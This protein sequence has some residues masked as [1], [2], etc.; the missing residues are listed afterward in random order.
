VNS[1]IPSGPEVTPGY[2]LHS[3][4]SYHGVIPEAVPVV[5]SVTTRRPRTDETPLGTFV[6]R[7]L[8]RSLFWGYE[9]TRVGD[10]TT[11]FVASPEKALLDLVHLTPGRVTEDYVESLRLEPDLSLDKLAMLADRTGKPKLRHAARVFR[12]VLETGE[13]SH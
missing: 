2:H 7:H 5:T 4:L 6:F 8:H 12:R 1:G 11:F 10:G 13:D 3:A 9:E